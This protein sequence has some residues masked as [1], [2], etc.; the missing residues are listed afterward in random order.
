MKK[1]VAIAVLTGAITL[2]CSSLQAAELTVMWYETDKNESTILKTLLSEYTQQHPAT[3]FNL[4]LVP[5]DNVIQKFRQ[6]A[7]SGS[8]M[9]DISKTSSMEAVIRPYLVDFNQYFGK[10][11]LDH[12]IKGWADGARLDGKAIAAPLYV[13]STGLLLNADAFKKAGV[14]LPDMKTGWTWEEFLPKIKEVAQKAH[15]RY[16][17]VWDVSASRW[18][19]HEYQYGNYVFSTQPPYKVVMDKQKAA[20]TLADFVHIADE[21]LPRGQWSG[22]SSDNPKELF[23]GGQAVAWM[24][25]S[26]QL[27]SLAQRAK[28]DWRAG[29]TPKGTVSSS[30]YGGE[31]VVAFNTSQHLQETTDVVKWLT[32]PAILKRLSV[33][34][35]MIPATL[36]DEPIDYNNAKISQAM[37]QM[38]RELVDSP[39]YAATDQANQAMQFVW[40]PI[41]D[42]VMQAVTHQITP[43]QAIDKITKAA[44][45]GLE[46]AK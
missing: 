45:D 6:Y 12:Y 29:Y 9:P 22:A 38:Q 32:S 20:K 41:K 34:I 19:I 14:A 4:Q 30:V 18:I 23:I 10:D 3:T 8:G 25:G 5:Y 39:A 31:Y 2:A 11:Y 7:A 40:A 21:Y 27:S 43:E 17:L 37:A 44:S 24:T 16:P 1:Q 15:I 36:S 33:P 28:F 35:G 26:W 46:A 42:A 13:T